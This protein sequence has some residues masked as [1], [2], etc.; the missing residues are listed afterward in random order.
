M[1]FRELAA[2]ITKLPARHSQRMVAI[3]GGGGAGKTTFTKYLH[4]AIP[5]SFVLT[6][7]AF[8]R[9]SQIR[10]PVSVMDGVNTNFDW[11]RFRTTVL[12]AV[13]QDRE[14]CY[15]RYQARRPCLTRNS[16][17]VPRKATIIVEG[18]WSLQQDFV[19]YY[20]YRIWLEAPP[21][22]R[23]QRGLERDGEEMREA[24]EKEWI[25]IDERYRELQKPYLSADCIVDS[26][27]SDFANDRIVTRTPSSIA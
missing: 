12:E 1:T 15:Q 3:D 25:P 13:C 6:I 5:N 17:H 7:D 19:P 22:I 20:D 2:R 24:W 11:D 4:R 10:T 23:L 27:E 8:Y 9:P 21:T 14:V 18:V 16:T 26:L